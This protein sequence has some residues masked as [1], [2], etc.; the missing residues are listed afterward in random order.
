MGVEHALICYVQKMCFMSLNRGF[1]H[2][3]QRENDS[4]TSILGVELDNLITMSMTGC[5]KYKSKLLHT[6]VLQ[7]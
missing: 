5:Q 4:S 7:S 1:T 2:N 3:S 6:E